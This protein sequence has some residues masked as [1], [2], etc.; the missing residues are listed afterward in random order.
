MEP[1]NLFTLA[2]RQTT[3]LSARQ[4][5]IASNVA[6]ADTPGY[7]AVDVPPFD[8]KQ[9]AS[10]S[11][12]TATNTGHITEPAHRK[13]SVEPQRSEDSYPLN[14]SGNSVAI[15]QELIKAKEVQRA[16]SLNTAIVKTFHR[17]S[18]TGLEG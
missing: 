7:R 2:A 12:V 18:L 14:H 13:H 11:T 8:P 6:N 5:A 10:G 15:E 3:W 1:V 16:H 17:L 9:L 4:T